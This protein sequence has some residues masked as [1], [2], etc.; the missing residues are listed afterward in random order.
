MPLVSANMWKCKWDVL[1]VWSNLAI[2]CKF[3]LFVVNMDVL[4]S[5]ER[6]PNQQ[7][8]FARFGNLGTVWQREAG[9]EMPWMWFLASRKQ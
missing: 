1:R 9:K 4:A 3:D 6:F 2:N 5:L 8:V 7:H